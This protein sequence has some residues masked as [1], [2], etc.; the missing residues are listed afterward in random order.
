MLTEQKLNGNIVHCSKEG[1]KKEIQA[2]QRS[3]SLSNAIL[4]CFNKL[5]N[6]IFRV[7][8]VPH[9]PPHIFEK[10]IS[11]EGID[12]KL[13]NLFCL[14]ENCKLDMKPVPYWGTYDAST[15]QSTG[16]VKEVRMPKTLFGL[17]RI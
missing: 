1:I 15:R 10:S 11:L 12:V 3:D 17:Y 4:L 6:N 9:N 16:L 7:G 14:K 5:S 8:F 2:S 13:M